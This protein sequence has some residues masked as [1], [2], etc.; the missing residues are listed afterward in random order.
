MVLAALYT[1]MTLIHPLRR[2]LG[3]SVAVGHG[4]AFWNSEL[5]CAAARV[6]K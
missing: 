4:K 5:E 6:Y 1:A 2:G 3:L